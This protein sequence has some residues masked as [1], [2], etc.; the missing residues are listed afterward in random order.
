MDYSTSFKVN[1]KKI[2]IDVK[3]KNFKRGKDICLFQT[4]IFKNKRMLKDGYIITKFP[5][6]YRSKIKNSITDLISSKLNNPKDFTLETYHKFVD[7]DIHKKVVDSFRGGYFG[8]GGI[9]LDNLGIPYDDFNSY[10][11]NILGSNLSCVYKKYGLTIKNFWIRIVRPNLQDNNPPHKDVH[12][13]RIN[14]NV[15]IY[16]PL[17]GSNMNSSL[18]IIPRSHLELENEYIISGSPCY[19]NGRKFT[20][21]SIVHRNKGLDMVTPNPKPNEILIFTPHLI[22]GGGINLNKDTTR[23]SLEMRFFA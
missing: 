4:P 10:I 12:V 13:R 6:N 1:Q 8:F 9:Q 23:V 21:P 18:P 20:V 11:N 19:V 3:S 15:N 16:L 17:A 22:H 2:K 7:D 14:N 5:I